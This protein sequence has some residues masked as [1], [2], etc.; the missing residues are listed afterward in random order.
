MA[1]LINT[2]I[3][4]TGSLDL[5]AGSTAQRPSSPVAGMV[6]YNTSISDTEYYDGTTWRP[7]ADTH[8]DATG[9]TIVDTSVSGINYRVHIFTT[10]G[11]STFTVSKTGEVEYLIV[12]GGGGGSDTGSG[13]GGAGGLLTGFTT[14]TPQAYTITV[15]GGG[16]GTN[17]YF[18]GTS[19]LTGGR[20]GNSVALGFTA[21]GG[22][23][24]GGYRT[25]ANEATMAGGS[26]GGHR[27]TNGGVGGT[28]TPGQGNNGGNS[29]LPNGEAASGG[30][31][32]GSVGGDARSGF[33]GDGGA[34]VISSITGT[35]R[36]YAGGGGG[37]GGYGNAV[38]SGIGGLGGGGNGG[39]VSRFIEDPFIQNGFPNTGGGGGGQGYNGDTAPVQGGG[40]GGSGIVVIRYRRNTVTSTA[41]TLTQ[42]GT[43]PFYY[44]ADSRSEVVRT[45][46]GLELDARDP[47]SYPGTG[48]VWFD[49]SGNGRNFTGNAAYINNV[50]GI[51]AG[52]NWNCPAASVNGLL[53]NDA[54]AIFFVIKFAT[55]VA[56]TSST[57]PNF[58]KFFEHPGGS[59]DR[60]PG[61]WRFPN[62]RTI[63]WRYQPDNSG[64]DFG[65][66]P[67]DAWVYFGQ[68][69][70][71]GAITLYEYG[72]QTATGGYTYPKAAGNVD[73]NLF[74]SYPE[75]LAYIANVMIY[76]RPLSAQEVRQNYEVLNR[77]YGR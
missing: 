1:Q 39:G 28:G 57:T 26:G 7:I 22:G 73:I 41:P 12:A 71:R 69:V 11:N 4:D 36:F 77:K 6:R 76:D 25:A 53:N 29:T 47:L 32:A 72:V 49:I 2:I 51:R 8:P 18:S 13:G 24:G 58:D 40:N 44:N 46:L 63:H 5:P 67:T 74:P 59:T 10:V 14:V 20:G 52:A 35:A 27:G 34:G 66:Y 30:G 45:G 56:N 37:S 65:S 42:R 38:R 33:G 68:S 61:L 17:S 19:G 48:N 75:S 62:A 43:L 54:H 16:A 50:S 31:G 3:D 70:N 64:L 9:G 60:S 23:G 15:G 55:T 21:I